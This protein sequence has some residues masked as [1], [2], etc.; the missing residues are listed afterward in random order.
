M[1]GDYLC[2]IVGKRDILV[3]YLLAVD[4]SYPEREWTFAHFSRFKV[5]IGYRWLRT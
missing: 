1:T 2:I 3:D 4:I 5:V